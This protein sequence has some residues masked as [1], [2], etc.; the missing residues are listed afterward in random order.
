M[1]STLLATPPRSSGAGT[2]PSGVSGSGSARLG[3][4]HTY[5]LFS[6]SAIE[7]RNL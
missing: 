6:A 1:D 3:K 7:K 4:A 2:P 5:A